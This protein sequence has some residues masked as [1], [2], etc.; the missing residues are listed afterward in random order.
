MDTHAYQ[1]LLQD[2]N[3]QRQYALWNK[4][5]KL[6]EVEDSLNAQVHKWIEEGIVSEKARSKKTVL[7]SVVLRDDTQA[8]PHCL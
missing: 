5:I 1:G 7:K 4:I 6:Y 3:R 2:H 8:V